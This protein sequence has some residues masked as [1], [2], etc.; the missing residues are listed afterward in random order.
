ML[1]LDL[2]LSSTHD[3]V[4]W[5]LKLC[6]AGASRGAASLLSPAEAPGVHPPAQVHI[7]KSLYKHC[8]ISLAPC[9]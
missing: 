1:D 7:L 8:I 4:Y 3:M 6:F 2:V 9:A 5:Y